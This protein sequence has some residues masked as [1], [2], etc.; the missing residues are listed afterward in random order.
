LAASS[1]SPI[2]SL[3]PPMLLETAPVAPAAAWMLEEISWVAA[4]CSSTAAEIPEEM[5][6]SSRTTLAMARMSSTE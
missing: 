3:T 4:F 2:V 5:S 6:I 1:V